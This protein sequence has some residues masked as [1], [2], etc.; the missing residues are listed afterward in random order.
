MIESY[1]NY[2]DFF[3]EEIYDRFVG[4]L[5][6]KLGNAVVIALLDNEPLFTKKGVHFQF[7]RYFNEFLSANPR[8]EK[9]YSRNEGKTFLVKGISEQPLAFPINSED[10]ALMVRENIRIPV[11]IPAQIDEFPRARKYHKNTAEPLKGQILKGDWKEDKFLAPRKMLVH[12]TKVYSVKIGKTTEVFTVNSKEDV[13]NLLFYVYKNKIKFARI[14]NQVFQFKERKVSHE[15][16]QKEN[17]P[18]LLCEVQQ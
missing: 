1:E 15:L 12:Y 4:Y 13:A 7:R 5:T 16:E 8:I 9:V 2:R 17:N 14:G 11:L 18:E 3:K 10:D 6:H